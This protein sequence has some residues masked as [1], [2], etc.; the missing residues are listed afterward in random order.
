MYL[1]QTGFW[2]AEKTA[3]L[4]LLNK[5][6]LESKG[7]DYMFER[8]EKWVSL[9]LTPEE[10]A[11]P[12]VQQMVWPEG[13]EI[14]RIIIRDAERTFMADEDRQKI[15]K[16]LSVVEHKFGDYAQGLSFLASLLLLFLP[17]GK[18][19]AMLSKINTDPKYIPGYWK[20]E[21][22]A[23]ARDAYVF[24]RFW[25]QRNVPLADHLNKTGALPETF[26]QKYMVA[27]S[28]HVLPFEALFE[29]LENFFTRGARYLFQFALSFVQ[30]L[31]K[32]LMAAND[33]PTVFAYLRLD[34]KMITY[35]EELPLAAVKAALEVDISDIDDDAKLAAVREEVFNLKLRG[36]FEALAAARAREEEEKRRREEKKKQKEENGDSGASDSEDDDDDSDFDS[37]G[38][39]GIECQI[40]ESNWPEYYCKDCDKLVCGMC[41]DKKRPPH[42]AGH[43]VKNADE[44]T[45]QQI[46]EKL[47]KTKL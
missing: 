45:I 15:A 28:I 6:Y 24:E 21:A 41:N 13:L 29:F 3:P 16:F 26:C 12:E 20:H 46:T 11:A 36:R 33:T 1:K 7:F 4:M 32:L 14:S 30:H 35:P 40:C 39:D 19:L 38:D 10:I 43:K 37:D 23:F 2:E 5:G 44:D 27:L 9:V 8:A 34:T 17:E 22:V 25:R 31:E 47:A 42:V 18:V